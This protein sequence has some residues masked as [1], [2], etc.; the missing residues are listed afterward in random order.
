MR[1]RSLGLLICLMAVSAAGC[2]RLSPDDGVGDEATTAEDARESDGAEGAAKDADA[3]DEAEPG[4]ADEAL[5]ETSG[6]GD[7][8]ADESSESDAEGASAYPGVGAASA[9]SEAGLADMLDAD[10]MARAEALALD[11]Q[12]FAGVVA[13]AVDRDEADAAGGV[14][15]LA[16]M[17]DRPSYR[18]LYTQRHA[19]KYAT[20]RKAEVAVYRYDTGKISM[21]TVD[22]STGEVEAL[23]VP[24][25]FPAPLVPEETR[26]AARLA[27]GDSQVKAALE[28]AGLDP[29][30]ALA[31]GLLT[32]SREPGSRCAEHRCLRLFFSSFED[33]RPRFAVI[34][35]L[36]DLEVVEIEDMPGF[37]AEGVDQ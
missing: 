37:D 3:S 18:V 28:A 29:D 7:A 4:E 31:N 26:E 16:R 12:S 33:P 8:A 21:S 14:S 10:E 23:A 19:D 32:V 20:S 13:Q 9:G 17:A 35:D 27:R 24:E 1:M 11:S 30:S 15:A 36:N 25:G 34:V 6:D 22:L 2:S 5:A